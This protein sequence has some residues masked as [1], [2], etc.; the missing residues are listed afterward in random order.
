MAH[1]P[2][3]Y[4]LDFTHIYQED[5]E[6]VLPH[7]HYIDC[8]DIP[9][10]DLYVTREAQEEIARRIRKFGPY[11]VHF[12]DNGNYHYVTG[13]ITRLIQEPFILFLFDHHTDMQQPMIHD[14]TS[15]G[16][17]AGE[18]LDQFPL[19]KQ[20]VLIGPSQRQIAALPPDIQEKV[21][22]ISMQ[23]LEEQEA[24][25]QFEKIRQDLPAYISID[26]DV[27]DRYSAR[28]NWNQGNMSLPTLVHLVQN[29]FSR[30]DILGVDICGECSLLEPA[31]CLAEDI[32]IDA[33]TD[34]V[35][36]HMMNE[37]LTRF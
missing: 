22:G 21:V 23:Q 11:G 26:K 13:I 18:L 28:T 27:L 17:W 4:I 14:L 29:V 7:L 15:C 35:L 10:T 19:L 36:Y 34:K 31:D 3:N 30:L 32:R 24:E 20:V 37:Y 2:I 8:S 33:H 25:V 6:Q 12:L 1:Q 9:G 5:M 16:S